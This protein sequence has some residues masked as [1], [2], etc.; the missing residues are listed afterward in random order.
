MIASEVLLSIRCAAVPLLAIA[1]SPRGAAGAPPSAA[2]TEEVSR[3]Q[4]VG[5]LAGPEFSLA[6]GWGDPHGQRERDTDLARVVVGQ[7]PIEA[8]AGFRTSFGLRVAAEGR[9]GAVIGR[10]CSTSCSGSDL[11]V[12]L[13]L[14]YHFT[15]EARVDHYVGVGAGYEWLALDVGVSRL[16]YR[17]PEWLSLR[18][19][20]EF[21]LGP[22]GIGPLLTLALGQFTHQE[23]DIPPVPPIEGPIADRTVHVWLIL[24]VRVS[25]GWH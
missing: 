13:G 7:V 8:A 1:L 20:E 9:Y 3:R 5:P 2:P 17:G 16:R 14:E 25:H 22:I 21:P 4:R 12:G 24:G 15:P 10:D 18:F 11:R 19:G 23:S 6:L